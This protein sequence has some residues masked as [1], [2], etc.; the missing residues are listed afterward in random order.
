M[1]SSVRDTAHLCLFESRFLFL[2]RLLV[3]NLVAC[4]V[5]HDGAATGTVS[6]KAKQ[7]FTHIDS[8]S[9]YFQTTGEIQ[10]GFSNIFLCKTG[11]FGVSCHVFYYISSCNRYLS[12]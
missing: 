4:E 9:A 7:A 8:T 5:S 2:F 10:H 1:G 3:N 12:P 6:A 11:N